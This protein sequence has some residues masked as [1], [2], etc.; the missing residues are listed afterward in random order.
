MI[1]KAKKQFL[2]GNGRERGI[3][4]KRV[5]VNYSQGRS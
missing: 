4:G 5:T 1:I 2:E 3:K